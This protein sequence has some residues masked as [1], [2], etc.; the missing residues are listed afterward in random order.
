MFDYF[1]NLNN[2]LGNT[3]LAGSTGEGASAFLNLAIA[4]VIIITAAKAGG[5]ISIRLKQPAVLGELLAG[6]I[7]GPTLLDFLH[8][9]VFGYSTEFTYG[10]LVGEINQLAEIGV[11]LL[12]FIAGLD[13]HLTD[14]LKSGKIAVLAGSLGVFVPMILGA[15][16]GLVYN[17]GFN[18]AIFI[19][20]VL[21]ATSV[22]ISAQTLME[23]GKLRTRAGIAMLGAAVF[24]DVLVVLGLSIFIALSTSGSTGAGDI[25]LII[26]RMVLYLVV[27]LGFGFFVLPKL[28]TLIEKLPISRGLLAFVFITMLFYAWLAEVVGLVAPIT[29]A[30]IAG[31]LFARSS[32]RDRIEHEI[33]V[34]AYGIFVPIF[35]VSVGLAANLRVLTWETVGLFVVLIIVAIVGKV[36]GSGIGAKLGGFT[37]R[38]SLQMGVGMM[39]RGEVGL[40][41][42]NQGIVLGLIGVDVFSA[43]V[44]V[45]LLTTLLTPILLRRLFT[46]ETPSTTV[47]QEA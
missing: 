40:I 26:L 33:S 19:G 5:Y 24:D 20:L 43:I 10:M 42:A 2:I 9:G 4:L 13:L 16:T 47:A 12:M 37:N 3:P 11:L 1:I 18:E 23:L 38:E 15:G 7:L 34:V 32:L 21:S 17:F 30:F 25:A 31:L 36:L 6:L 45:V 39:S 35:F 46:N 27:A 44:G 8:W 14:L 22:S 28:T 41:V 29:G